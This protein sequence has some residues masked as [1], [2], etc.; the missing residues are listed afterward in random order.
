VK[1]SKLAV[2]AFISSVL[3]AC[4]GGS[5]S[6]PPTQNPTAGSAAKYVG[7]WRNCAPVTNAAN[8]VM[9]ASTDFVFT[10]SGD[11][12]LSL[13][14]NA[15]G[16]TASACGGAPFNA[17]DN[18]ATGSVT[19]AGTKTVSGLVVDLAEFSLISRQSPNLNGSFLDI[20][21]VEGNA[22]RLGGPSTPD[23]QGYP[24]ALDTTLSY[25]K[26]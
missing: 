8:G 20:M 22:L 12:S 2:W 10:Q 1:L 14:V 4:G 5:N 18:F 13:V 7:T 6:P 3:A 17:I 26:Q 23:A 24:T 19:L 21:A 16:Y 15:K 9:S 11:S 25:T